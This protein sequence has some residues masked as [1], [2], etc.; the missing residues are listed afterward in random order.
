VKFATL[1]KVFLVV[2]FLI[3]VTMIMLVLP[4]MLSQWNLEQRKYE[5]G[6]EIADKRERIS[7]IR[8]LLRK[9]TDPQVKQELEQEM[10]E[11]NQQVKVLEQ[12]AKTLDQ[13]ME[14]LTDLLEE[15]RFINL[16]LLPPNLI[17]AGVVAV[18]CCLR[19]RSEEE[20]KLFK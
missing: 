18:T 10:E 2:F 1:Q 7:D 8:S 16:A 5:V 19:I 15:R 12:E 20:E 6:K 17:I 11:L 14:A 3:T 4:V 13:E 9:T